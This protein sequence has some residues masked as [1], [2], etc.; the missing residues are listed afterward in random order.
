MLELAMGEG[1]GPI[2]VETIAEKQGI[3]AKYIHVLAT[4]LRKAGFLRATRGPNGGYTLAKPSCDIS[5]LEI[6]ETLDGKEA[7][8]ECLDSNCVCP[9]FSTCAPRDLWREMA[10]AVEAVLSRHSLADLVQKQ[11][12]KKDVD[13]VM[14][15]I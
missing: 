2:L 4:A 3:S 7:L 13:Q 9:R 14:Y 6:I 1:K 12:D 11:R 5:A 8:V 15:H 10:D